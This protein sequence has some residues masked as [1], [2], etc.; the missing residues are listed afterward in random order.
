MLGSRVA[1]FVAVAIALFVSGLLLA[2]CGGDDEAQTTE[3]VTLPTTETAET[4][5]TTETETTETETTETETTT[6]T[7]DEKPVV[8]R[9]TVLGGAPRDG[10]VRE[11]A[12]EGDKVVL[13]VKS[14]EAD[15][16]H[17]HGYDLYRDLVP[18]RA[19]RIAFVAN[20][21]GRFAIELHH[22]GTQIGDLTVR[23]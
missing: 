9:I 1:A 4:T 5:E 16:V 6:T 19:A 17:V 14:D 12:R 2:S 15:E 7:E 8:L 21:P 13:V 3:T 10:I 18:G 11:T 22:R 23:P 20:L